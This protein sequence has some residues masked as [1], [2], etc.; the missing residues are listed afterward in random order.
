M[1]ITVT[2]PV[3]LSLAIGNTEQHIKDISSLQQQITELQQQLASYRAQLQQSGGSLNATKQELFVSEKSLTLERQKTR[4]LEFKLEAVGMLSPAA[5]GALPED[6]TSITENQSDSAEA[7]RTEAATAEGANSAV[8]STKS[9][10]DLVVPADDMDGGSLPETPR[11]P[12][13]SIAGPT[14]PPLSGSICS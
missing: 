13:G 1:N 4:H 6:Q 3:Y 7:D 14:V 12:K 11:P 2:E 5:S 10:E 9:M 8:A